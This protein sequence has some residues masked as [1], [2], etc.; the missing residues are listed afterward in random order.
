[1]R[2]FCIFGDDDDQE[3]TFRD[4]TEGSGNTKAGYRKIQFCAKQTAIDDLR[5]FWV[6]T[7]CIDT[8]NNTELSE[9]INSLFRCYRIVAKCY[10]YMSDISINSHDQNNL[11]FQ[12]QEAAFRKIKWF[13]RGW[14]LT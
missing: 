14:T 5:H 13:T 7:C 9:A 2:Y 3:P 6:D 12:L 10:V 11:S 1:M 8:S 4:F